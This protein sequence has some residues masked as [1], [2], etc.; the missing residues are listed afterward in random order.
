MEKKKTLPTDVIQS[1]AMAPIS[2]TELV[3]QRYSLAIK[4]DFP[5]VVS[6][7][8]VIAGALRSGEK[9]SHPRLCAERLLL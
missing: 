7:P 5:A 3:S 9:G 2:A 8:G 1:S 6:A 4:L